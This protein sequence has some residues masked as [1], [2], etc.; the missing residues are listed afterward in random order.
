MIKLKETKTWRRGK[1]T[2]RMG[3]EIITDSRKIS[4][5]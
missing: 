1:I 5:D 4:G 2:E 3:I